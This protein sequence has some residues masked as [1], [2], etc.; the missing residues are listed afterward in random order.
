MCNPRDP[1]YMKSLEDRIAYLETQ[2]IAHGIE[3]VD[4]L[5]ADFSPA[6]DNPE[7]VSASTFSQETD[8][9]SEDLV[10]RI[11]LN[12]LQ[13]HTFPEGIVNQNGLSLLRSLLSDSITKVSWTEKKSDNHS[14]LDELPRE[15]YTRVPR[16]EVANRL[17]DTYFEHCNFFSPIISSKEDFLAVIEPLYDNDSASDRSLANIRFRAL[18]V[19]GTS[20]LLLN[21]TDASVPISRSE[22]YFTAATQ[23]FSQHP[24]AICTGDLEHLANLL[25]II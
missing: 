21:R 13:P 10:R 5:P 3:D 14:L 19:F 4:M 2:L 8:A 18:V 7:S 23:L 25:F 24:D 22:G 17:V 9:D 11:A 15:T 20:I 6:A 12:C 16:K 1:S